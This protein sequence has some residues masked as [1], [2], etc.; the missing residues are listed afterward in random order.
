M[1]QRACIAGSAVLLLAVACRPSIDVGS[2]AQKVLEID[3]AWASVAGAG[4]NIDSAVSFWT[5]DARVIQSG[6]PTLQG[7]AAIRA[8]VTSVFAIPGFHITWTPESAVVSAAGDLAYTFGTNAVTMPDAKG[9][10]VT[11]NGRYITVWRKGADGRWR[12]VM[13]YTNSGPGE[14]TPTR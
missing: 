4:K 2:E 12:C 3:R 8:M 13:D 11:E 1:S 7:K 10:L 14:V 9:K 6:Q 5:D